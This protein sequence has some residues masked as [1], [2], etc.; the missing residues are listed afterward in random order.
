M[1][2]AKF[3][4]DETE[5]VWSD[6]K[7][8]EKIDVERASFVTKNSNISR[9]CIWN[10]EKMDQKAATLSSQSSTQPPPS[11]KS[12]G[13]TRA[14]VSPSAASGDLTA[15]ATAA[16]VLSLQGTVANSLQQAT[17]RAAALKLQAF[18]YYLALQ[19]FRNSDHDTNDDAIIIEQSTYLNS[20]GDDA[21]DTDDLRDDD[22][23]PLLDSDDTLP[24]DSSP[25]DSP[26]E[27]TTNFIGGHFSGL[28]SGCNSITT[29]AAA[30]AAAATT[31]TTTNT[32][33]SSLSPS[34]TTAASPALTVA[35]VSATFGS[36]STTT[37]SQRPKKQFICKFCSRH[38]TKSYNLLIHE[39]THT[40]ERP[41][42]CDV[43]N[44]A[45]R[46]QDHLRDHRW[47]SRCTSSCCC[48]C[49][50]LLSN[51]FIVRFPLVSDWNKEDDDKN[52]LWPKWII[53]INV[54]CLSR[55]ESHLS[56][57]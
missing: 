31:I 9:K 49:C 13:K 21:N 30:A 56:F 42:S 14:L 5:R 15:A 26:I 10:G 53:S 20:F 37:A 50:C 25:L 29:A 34:S 19:R 7:K 45:F 11:S 46:R 18:E 32:S 51:I 54:L 28:L 47:V 35:A 16:Y 24:F 57:W 55:N 38:F 3:Q 40:D 52:C 1:I 43:C 48:C 12:C 23:L 8:Q 2:S 17:L 22:G 39:R 6:R 41:Y 4:R 33:S 44:K 36:S 27:E